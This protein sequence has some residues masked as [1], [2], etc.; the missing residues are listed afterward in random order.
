LEHD[1]LAGGLMNLLEGAALFAEMRFAYEAAVKGALEKACVVIED[2]AKRV[3][4]SYDYGWRELAESTQAERARLGFPPN[5]PLLR[6]GEMRDSLEHQVVLAEKKGYVGS[7]DDKAVWQE[8]GTSR[9]IP[10]RSF[11]G[12]AA[13]HKGQEAAE[14]IGQKIFFALT[15]KGAGGYAYNHWS[16]PT[17][18]KFTGKP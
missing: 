10:P 4:G 7:N 13:A 1:E 6:T 15:S 9:G 17:A 18:G 12:G 2:E 11:L 5:E 8:L 3:I 16:G 14:A